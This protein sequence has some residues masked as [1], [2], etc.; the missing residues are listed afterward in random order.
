MWRFAGA[1]VIGTSHRLTALPCQDAH[2]VTIIRDSAGVEVLIVCA[3]DGAGTA[4]FAEQGAQLAVASFQAAT[5]LHFAG[6]KVS[7]L[8]AHDMASLAAQTRQALVDRS[9]A[10]AADLRS[11]ACTFLAAVIGPHTVG[12]CQI[13]DG[14][15]I[16]AEATDEADWSW[17]FWPQRGEFA[18]ATA[19]LTDDDALSAIEVDVAHRRIEEIA[20][21]TDGL[22]RM[23]LKYDT[24][25]VFSPFFET[26]FSPVRRSK[27]IGED[28]ALRDALGAYLDSSPVNQRTDDDK[29]LVLASRRTESTV[30]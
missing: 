26:M 13:G 27:A 24:R 18:N 21:L 14:V 6:K 12:F 28:A 1:S 10:N 30:A 11:F 4:K 17:V 25:S 3:S 8:T 5:Q 29:T 7:D 15:T 20:L 2:A 9:V 22:E 16:V 23:V 19:F